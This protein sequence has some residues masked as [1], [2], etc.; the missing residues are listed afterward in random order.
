MKRIAIIFLQAAVVLIGILALVILGWFPL[1]EGRAKN[2]DLFHI[3]ADPL[4][5]YGYAASIAFFIGLYKGFRLLGYIGQDKAYSLNAVNALRGIKYCAIALAIL[6]VMAGLYIM[7]AHHKDDDPA[8]FFAICIV[9]AFTAV[10][11]AV[12]AG[13]FEKSLRNAL[14]LK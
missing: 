1:T 4:L 6:I 5:L 12:T 7:M 13:R 2:L 9:T 3:Y 10:V 14:D 11:V 8:G